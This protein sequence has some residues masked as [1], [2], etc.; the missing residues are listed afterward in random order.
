MTLDRDLVRIDADD[1]RMWLPMYT[2]KNSDVVQQAAS[3]GVDVLYDHAL[4]K[5]MSLILDATYTPYKVAHQNVQRSLKRGRERLTIMVIPH[6]E[7]KILNLHVS[8]YAVSITFIM[9]SYCCEA[10]EVRRPTRLICT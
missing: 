7:K 9:V 4:K 3:R 5:G 2:G 8:V 1:V 10:G 6:T